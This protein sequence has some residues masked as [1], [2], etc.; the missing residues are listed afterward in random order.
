MASITAPLDTAHAHVHLLAADR[1]ALAAFL[2]RHSRVW[3]S[4]VLALSDLACLILAGALAAWIRSLVGA[5]IDFHLYLRF[6]PVLLV[7]IAYFYIRGL[8]PAIGLGAVEEFRRLVVNLTMIFIAITA[9]SFW[10]QADYVYSRVVFLLAWLF[11]LAFLPFGRTLARALLARLDLWGEPVAI[12]GP[13]A[14]ARQIAASLRDHPKMGRRPAALFDHSD[15]IARTGGVPV[16]PLAVMAGFAQQHGIRSALVI[17]DDLNAL[18]LVRDMYRDVFERVLFVSG[19]EHAL[20]LSGVSVQ[21]FGGLLSLEIRQSLLDRWA[22]LQKRLIDI[23]ASGLLLAALSP[24]LALVA[25]L[26]KIDSRGPVFYYQVRLGKGGRPF[27]MP[28]FRTMYRN[29]DA[30]L[31]SVLASDPCAKAEWDCYQKLKDDPRITRVGK[32]LRRFSIDEL[33]QIWNVFT[34]EMSL[35]GP[36]PILPDQKDLY[37]RPFE[38][39]TRVTPGM[40]GLWQISGRN[41]TSFARRAELDLHYVMNWSLWWDVYILVRTVW[42][43]LTRYGAC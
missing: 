29:A 17:Y 22:Q 31:Q 40:T 23:A 39:Y 7:F 35:V 5:G 41:R 33:P 3:M 27:R 8:Y 25:L 11:S 2:L 38:H 1:G 30:V 34:G 43:V 6:I 9:V 15:Y 18:P 24:F 42:V 16:L 4:H 21:D 12:L 20:R 10:V 32:L 19:P 28:K 14:E 37:G 26:I 13:L 36:R